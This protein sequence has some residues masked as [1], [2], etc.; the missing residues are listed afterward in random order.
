[1]S[2]ASIQRSAVFEITMFIQIGYVIYKRD[3]CL[4]RGA[5]KLFKRV[6]IDR[7]ITKLYL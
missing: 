4:S 3:R 2:L 5:R 1:M 6:K 7:Y